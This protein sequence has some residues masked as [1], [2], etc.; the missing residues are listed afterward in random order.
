MSIFKRKKKEVPGFVQTS[1]GRSLYS[2]FGS[3]S[4][5]SPQGR[6]QRKLYRSLRDAV[7]VIDAAINKIVRLSGGF[8]VVCEDKRLRSVLMIF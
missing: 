7:P 1:Q 5:A 3:F 2:A 4:S 8:K 6:C